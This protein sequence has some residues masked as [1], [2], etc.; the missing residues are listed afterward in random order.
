MQPQNLKIMRSIGF[1][2]SVIFFSFTV[3][4][5]SCDSWF[6]EKG[7]G[8]HI[9]DITGAAM[10]LNYTQ[11]S[12]DF[13]AIIINESDTLSMAVSEGDLLYVMFQEFESV[14]FYRYEKADGNLLSFS[15]DTS[16]SVTYLNDEIIA[17]DLEKGGNAWTWIEHSDPELFQNIRSLNISM[18]IPE[19]G[20]RLLGEIASVNPD[21]GLYINGK[22]SMEDLLK[23]FTPEWIFAEDMNLDWLSGRNGINLNDT[24]LLIYSCNDS[25]K[26]DFLLNLSGL[27]S[28]LL[29]DCNAK[30][31]TGFP[32]EKLEKLE[33]LCII[34]SD[35]YD[36]SFLGSLPK[37]RNLNLV[38][39]EMLETIG[40]LSGLKG[41]EGLGFSGCGNIKDVHVIGELPELERLSLPS[42]TGQEEF[43]SII[44]AQHSLQVLELLDCENIN[45]LSPL[46]ELPELDILTVSIEDLDPKS[47]GGLKELE[48]L[49]LD[50]DYFE[51]SLKIVSLKQALPDTKIVPGG[52]F[53]LGSG[54]LLL[55]IP[56]V[57][58]WIALKRWRVVRA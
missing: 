40:S 52:T 58:L 30:G 7:E 4:L 13:G 14:R 54:W 18:P 44:K 51:D 2:L 48:L 46:I 22:G 35:I 16:T 23:L 43:E 36:L 55:L 10:V 8:Y 3:L 47:L 12:F 34:E 25:G 9:V 17:L 41:L 37:L 20:F 28:L 45:D 27:E 56:M 29:S 32:F 19:E 39:C 53:C 38:D 42:G 26:M 57:L 11:S 49:V 24:E 5:I 15:F 33:S 6:D 21:P 50:K 1:C 31:L